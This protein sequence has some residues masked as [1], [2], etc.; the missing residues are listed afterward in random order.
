VKA[1]N[2]R[3]AYASPLT[4]ATARFPDPFGAFELRTTSKQHLAEAPE[5][6][7]REPA[8]YDPEHDV[9]IRRRGADGS[10]RLLL[11]DQLTVSDIQASHRRERADG[12]VNNPARGQPGTAEHNKNG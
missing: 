5:D 6:V 2:E 8:R 11:V 4:S 1:V 9:S 7:A 3:P 12:E 10:H